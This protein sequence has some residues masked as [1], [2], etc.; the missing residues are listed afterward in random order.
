TLL[1]VM[2]LLPILFLAA[3]AFAADPKVI[4]LWPGSAPGS[5]SWNYDE[6]DTV[7][8]KDT[9]HRLSNITHPTLTVYQPDPALATGTAVIV[10]PGGGFRFLTMDNEG[11]DAARW[12]NS[13]GV[14]AFVLKY[15]VMRTGDG[16]AN[17]PAKMAERRKTVVP[18][19]IADGQQ[20]IRF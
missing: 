1:A 18:M 9:F 6:I 20:A 3:T 7:G 12:L 4:P 5:E 11:S 10:C 17:D 19:A 16:E 8:P 13:I 15:R 2:R 14:T